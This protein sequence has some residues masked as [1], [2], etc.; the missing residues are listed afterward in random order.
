MSKLFYI[1]ILVFIF[2]SCKKDNCNFQ[3]EEY[4]IEFSEKAIN[5]NPFLRLNEYVILENAT[6][7]DTTWIKVDQ[8]AANG[9]G[10][11]ARWVCP[12]DNSIEEDYI[13]KYSAVE[14]FFRIP[15]KAFVIITN[16]TNT[17]HINDPSK[18]IEYF[19]VLIA[20]GFQTSPTDTIRGILTK[21]I[22]KF[23]INYN[24]MVD[25][26]I[27][28]PDGFTTGEFY[29]QISIENEVFENVWYGSAE[30]LNSYF[31]VYYSIEKGVLAFS[32]NGVLY[33]IIGYK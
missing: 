21:P 18:Y 13:F 7:I 32:L 8:E 1:V 16:N 6:G 3:Y 30:F 14:S 23:D 20:N 15:N 12:S 26:P 22:I 17:P 27:S 28:F 19:Q 5:I 31:E 9:N 25:P 2:S 24:N 33:K 29:N 4:T 11:S 10:L